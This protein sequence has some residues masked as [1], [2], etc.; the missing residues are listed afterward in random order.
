MPKLTYCHI[1]IILFSINPDH[2][3]DQ[4]EYSLNDYFWS[5]YRK[6]ILIKILRNDIGKHC[7]MKFFQ[8]NQI[9]KFYYKK[10]TIII[11]DTIAHF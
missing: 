11:I 8:T 3:N 4:Y 10:Q 5:L 6:L 2:E 9:T 7:L 1:Y